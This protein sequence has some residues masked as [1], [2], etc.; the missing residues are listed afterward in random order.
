[1][2]L[3]NI[4]LFTDQHQCLLFDL[5]PM[6]DSCFGFPVQEY[7]PSHASDQSPHGILPEGRECVTNVKMTIVLV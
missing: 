2:Q 3:T 1:M 6:H 7:S 4:K 5:F